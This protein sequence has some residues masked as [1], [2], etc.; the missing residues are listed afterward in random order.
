MST[1]INAV[2][3]VFLALVNLP[4]LIG[5]GFWMQL[6]TFGWDSASAVVT[7]SDFEVGKRGA[8]GRV[9]YA[10]EGSSPPLEFWNSV[11]K[12]F[13]FGKEA[14]I[15]SFIDAHAPGT[16]HQVYISND[17]RE[18]SLGH[19]PRDYEYWTVVRGITWLVFAGLL[20][21]RWR[22]E[23]RERALAVE[24]AHGSPAEGSGVNSGRPLKLEI[25]SPVLREQ[26]QR[27]SRALLER[28]R[29]YPSDEYA[30]VV[31]LLDCYPRMLTDVAHLQDCAE[32]SEITALL[33]SERL[34][35]GVREFFAM[36][37]PHELSQT[38]RTM[39]GHLSK[40]IGEEL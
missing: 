18:A 27:Q 32:C 8:Y 26:Y 19:F 12:E 38:A 2:I 1:K 29:P 22:K 16:K 14:K 28:E 31:A 39:R 6:R 30:T 9:G 24:L 3:C 20:A 21:Q 10:I 11:S 13:T 5:S 7:A 35:P 15:K 33:T 40:L 34:R 23:D 25:H 4:V 37:Q 17:R 36:F